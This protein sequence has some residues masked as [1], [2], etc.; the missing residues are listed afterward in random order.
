MKANHAEMVKYHNQMQLILQHIFATSEK[1]S[2]RDPENW[3]CRMNNLVGGMEY[4]HAH[5]DQSWPSDL[6]GERTFPF[7]ATHGFGVNPFEM[8]LLPKGQRGQQAYGILH[9]FPPTA[10]LFMR[11]DFVHAGGAMWF[12]R[13]HMKFYPK[14]K[15]GLVHN[16]KDNYWLLP[17]FKVD[18]SHEQTEEDVETSF[19]W[20]HH[21]FP[22]ALP[23]RIRQFNDKLRTV[24]EIVSFPPE[25]TRTLLENVIKYGLVSAIKELKDM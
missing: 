23:R 6:E 24:E 11:G 5:S 12:P 25:M 8:W 9:Q 4:Q 21:I 14:V 13:C 18:I 22:F 20:Q 7:V 1:H 3:M 16:R 15:A 17:E 10:M 2:R 19:L